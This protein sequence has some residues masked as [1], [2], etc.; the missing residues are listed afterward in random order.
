MVINQGPLRG[1]RIPVARPMLALGR[2]DGCD[3]SLPDPQTSR[4][5]AR[6]EWRSDGLYLID[7]NSTNGTYVN[8]SRVAQHRLRGG[9]QVRIGNTVFTIQLY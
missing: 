6:L 7:T 8:R 5:H 2:S 3:I 4:Q 9:E 1:H